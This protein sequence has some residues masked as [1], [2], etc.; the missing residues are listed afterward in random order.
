LH[1]ASE[2]ISDQPDKEILQMKKGKS[3]IKEACD[4]LSSLGSQDMQNIANGSHMLT[5]FV[6]IVMAEWLIFV[7]F[8]PAR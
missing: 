2:A 8:T 3:V 6:T 5:H 7:S 4:L 1:T